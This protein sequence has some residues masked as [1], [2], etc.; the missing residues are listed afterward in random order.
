MLATRISV[1]TNVTIS[2]GHQ[3]GGLLSQAKIS[4]SSWFWGMEA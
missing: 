3:F 1:D 2:S 4:D